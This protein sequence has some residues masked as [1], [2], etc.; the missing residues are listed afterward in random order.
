MNADF[1]RVAFHSN[2]YG[3]SAESANIMF[4]LELPPDLL[5]RVGLWRVRK[6]HL[7]YIWKCRKLLERLAELRHVFI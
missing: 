1:T 2:W 7:F 6:V 4:L 5:P 3:G